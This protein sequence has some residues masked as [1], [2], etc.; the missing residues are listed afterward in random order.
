MTAARVLAADRAEQEAWPGTTWTCRPS[1]TA[2]CAT[3]KRR[4]AA[5]PTTRAIPLFA[6][7]SDDGALHIFHGMVYQVRLQICTPVVL[8]LFTLRDFLYGCLIAD[9]L[10]WCCHIFRTAY[11]APIVRAAHS[12]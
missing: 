1:P 8:Q 9:E 3:T 7:A 12:A 4:C 10:S 2:R 6:S 5:W 11:S